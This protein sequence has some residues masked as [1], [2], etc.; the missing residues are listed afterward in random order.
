MAED[1]NSALIKSVGISLPAYE[2]GSFG[3]FRVKFDGYCTLLKLNDNERL[4]ILPLCFASKRF[5]A[6]WETIDGRSTANSVLDRLELFVRQEE[7]PSDPLQYLIS[8]QWLGHETAYEF[9]RELRR[10]ASFIT[11]HKAS[12]DDIVKLQVIRII[13]ELARSCVLEETSVDELTRIMAVMGRPSD[14]A[15][16][17]AS[18]DVVQRTKS[19]IVCYNCD[20]EGHVSRRCRQQRVV[21]DQCGT[22]GHLK[23]FCDSKNLRTGPSQ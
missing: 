18:V 11:T 2:K 15:V 22:S 6:I 9:T 21:C 7:R 8:R 17:A 10:R 12:I 4:G 14:S 3:A 5:D 1:N 13:P 20:K 23:K 19:R 16:A